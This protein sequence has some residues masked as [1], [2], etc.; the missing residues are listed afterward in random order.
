M[1]RLIKLSQKIKDEKLRKMVADFLTSPS[2]S[3]KSFKKYSAVDIAKAATPFT[4]GGVSQGAT[5]ERDVLNHTITLAD[6]CEKVAAVFEKSYGLPMN[7]DYLIAAA[8]VHDVAKVFEWKKGATGEIEHT[9]ILLDHTML[10][11]A[12]LYCRGFPEEVIH[13]VASHFGESGPT[14]PRNFEALVFHHLDN[15]LSLV[16][17]RMLAPAAQASQAL[18][19]V[20]LDEEMLRNL[21]GGTDIIAK[22]DT[23]TDDAGK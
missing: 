19:M 6:L 8:L 1:E 12:E 10:G 18:Q 11:T 17:F 9:G 2:L 13:I 21:G 4:V 23:P 16:E 22:E 7:S 14:P 15:M 20:L 3:S 5:V